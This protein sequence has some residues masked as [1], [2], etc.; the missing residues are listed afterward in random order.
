M[1]FLYLSSC[2]DSPNYVLCFVVSSNVAI[3]GH[4]LKGLLFDWIADVSRMISSR[5]ENW[6]R[7]A[8]YQMSPEETALELVSEMLVW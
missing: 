3:N 1:S 4:F 8:C 2:F 7:M 5:S 6:V